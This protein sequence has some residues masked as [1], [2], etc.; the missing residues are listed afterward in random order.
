MYTQCLL[1]ELGSP[2]SWGHACDSGLQGHGS[3]SHFS[4]TG[5][6][7]ISSLALPHGL[8]G[9]VHPLVPTRL[10]C[11]HPHGVV[12]GC[13]CW[14]CLPLCALGLLHKCTSSWSDL[15]YAVGEQWCHVSAQSDVP[16]CNGARWCGMLLH[17]PPPPHVNIVQQA[18]S[19]IRLDQ[20]GVTKTCQDWRSHPT[21]TIYQP[22][23]KLI[24]E[25]VHFPCGALMSAQISIFY[26]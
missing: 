19:L 15:G 10:L 17:S 18:Q 24:S 5:H 1:D 25:V 3:S 21:S 22:W 20:C 16:Q 26:C 4:W 7:S 6:L 8:S 13:L 2:C 12:M 9:D 23:P 14:H 11:K